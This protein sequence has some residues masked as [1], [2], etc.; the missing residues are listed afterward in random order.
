MIASG[1]ADERIQPVIL[2]GGSGTRLW[3][4]SR[5]LYPK[6]FL[7]LISELTMVQETAR[8]AAENEGF[9]A[10]VVVCN[11]EHRF[12]VAEQLREIGIRPRAILLEPEGRNTAPAAA[13]AALVAAETDE[14]PLLLILPSDHAIADAPRFRAALEMAA[15]AARSGSLVTFGMTPGAPETG[16]GYIQQ[17][18]VLA[19][20]PGCH[21][22]SRFVEKPAATAAEAMLAEGDWFW[23]SG[24]F[25]FSARTYLDELERLRP[26]IV[27]AC[28][29]AIDRGR[30]DLDFFRLDA[31][32][33]AASPAVSIDY[34]VMEQTEV[35][36]VVPVD[37]GWSD[38]GSWSAL[39]HIGDKDEW[40]NVAIGE[41]VTDNVSNS[42]LRAEGRLV[43]AIGIQDHL[44]VATDD[45][46][47]VAPMDQAQRVGNLVEK[48]K[49]DGN[50]RHLSHSTVFRPWGSYRSL[51]L[52][53]RFQV[54]H[55]MV[56]PGAK[57]S[58]QAHKHRAEHWVVVSGTARVTHGDETFDL[59]TNQSTFIPIGVRHRL[60]N[61]GT[62]PLRVIEVQ[63]GDY[64]GE[65]D[66]QRFDDVYGRT[67]N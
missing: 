10:P 60:E 6:P 7:P 44:I 26:G 12:L 47:L 35:S 34:A 53:T 65:D 57:L 63:S 37:M 55:L 15:V 33:F 14:D 1:L 61:P 24:I 28:R 29:T 42:Y 39:W 67:G 45:A 27:T 52:G 56:K 32:A 38:I 31:E 59:A 3:P 30:A 25:L 51:E 23:N 5:A 41:V 58:L 2:L 18:D 66:I 49:A 13:A 64:L 40:G 36:A 16:Y 22:V 43:A 20:A 17:G 54:K 21:R 50:Q 4:L 62:E 48:L 19:H 9:Q 11:H 46:V 8:R